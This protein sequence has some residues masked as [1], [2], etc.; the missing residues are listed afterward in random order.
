MI[1][2]PV[3]RKKE[4]SR[5]NPRQQSWDSQQISVL[6][7]VVFSLVCGREN[8]KAVPGL[9]AEARLPVDIRGDPG[10]DF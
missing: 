3:Y 2:I 9:R 7:T 8:S 6:R 4:F 5:A 10:V 1:K